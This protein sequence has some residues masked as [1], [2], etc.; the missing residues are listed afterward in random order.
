VALVCKWLAVIDAVIVTVPAQDIA[1]SAC[2]E[3]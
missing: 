1:Y 3:W 2:E